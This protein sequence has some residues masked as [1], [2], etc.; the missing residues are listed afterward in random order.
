MDEFLNVFFFVVHTTWMVFNCVGWIWRRTRPWHLA[1]LILTGLSWFGLGIWYG[2]G[3]CPCTDWHWQ[4]RQR[5]GYHDPPSYT[6]LLMDELTGVD[7]ST[8]AANVITVAVFAV[9]LTLSVTL[10]VRDRRRGRTGDAG[11][12]RT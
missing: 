2:W 12:V 6:E 8:R 5:L 7:V 1:S 3:Y 10:T 9:S 4:V 11:P